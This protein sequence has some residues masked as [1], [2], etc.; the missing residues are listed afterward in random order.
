VSLLD[1]LARPEVF[2]ALLLLADAIEG[3][4][5]QFIGTED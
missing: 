2:L 3:M 5:N 1:H 4:R